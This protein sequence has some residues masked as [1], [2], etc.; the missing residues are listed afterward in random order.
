M[1]ENKVAKY[2][3]ALKTANYDQTVSNSHS[4]YLLAKI[5]GDVYL[6]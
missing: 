3:L 6:L 2:I 5:L 4:K 1:Y